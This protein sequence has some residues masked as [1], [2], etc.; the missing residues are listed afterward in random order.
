MQTHRYGCVLAA[1]GRGRRGRRLLG[2]K[3]FTAWS[4]TE[5]EKMLTDS[6]WAK[7]QRVVLGT[8][9]EAPEQAPAPPTIPGASRSGPRSARVVLAGG[10]QFDRIRRAE[11]TVTWWATALPIRQAHVR[12]AIGRDAPVPPD[13]Q[14]KL[15]QEA[16]LYV[17]TV[18]GLPSDFGELAR[19]RDTVK[20]ATM[21]KRENSEPMVPENVQFFE[22]SRGL[23]RS[24]LS[25]QDSLA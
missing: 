1:R 12:Q 10:V 8:L 17:V 22:D 7:Q 2:G 5:V 16:P 13:A 6:P 25:R 9:S 23:P 15:L 24:R 19:M 4:D 3:A 20:A 21:V 18:A 14:A 11:V